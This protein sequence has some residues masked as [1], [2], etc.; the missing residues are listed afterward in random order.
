[1]PTDKHTVALALASNRHRVIPRRLRRG[2]A[3]RMAA[4]ATRGNS[5][6]ASEEGDD[7]RSS[8]E[9]K[10]ARYGIRQIFLNGGSILA[11]SPFL[12]EHG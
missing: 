1:M 7:D 3:N 12:Q 11:K 8:G 10:E 2:L 4:A 9:T 5:T 6:S